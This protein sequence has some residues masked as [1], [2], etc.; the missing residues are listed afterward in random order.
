MAAAGAL[1]KVPEPRGGLISRDDVDTK[2]GIE[3]MVKRTFPMRRRNAARYIAIAGAAFLTLLPLLNIIHIIATTGAN[4]PSS[5]DA[6]FM[7]RFLGRVLD[8]TYDWRFFIR[9]TFFFT[10][11]NLFPA[12]AYIAMARL[13]HFNVYSV[14]Y[15]GILLAAIK[16]A[17]IHNSFT[18]LTGARRGFVSLALWP[19]LSTLVFSVSQISVF[20]HDFQTMCMGFN[21]LGLALGV[22]GLAR[23]PNTLK[24]TLVMAAGGVIA[25]LSFGSGP[26]AWPL[27]LIGL[28]LL[29]CR[30]ILHYAIWLAAAALSTMP[31]IYFLILNQPQGTRS[32]IKSLF[33][34]V[35]VIDTI[36]R[37]FSNNI[38]INHLPLTMATQNGILGLVLLTIGLVLLASRRSLPALRQSVPA[39]SFIASSLLSAWQISIFRDSIAPWYTT[40]SMPFWLGLIG[41]AYVLWTNRAAAPAGASPRSRIIS[42]TPLVWGA[43]T[44]LLIAILFITSNLTFADKTIFLKTRAPASAAS[45]R[46]Y[47]TAP[48]Y[49]ENTL[50]IWPVG[51]PYYMDVMGGLL[52]KHRLSAFSDHQQWTLQGDF[53]LDTVRLKETPGLP[54]VWWSADL[55]A[56]PVPFSDYRHLNLFLHTP[57][58]VSWTVALPANLKQAD[59]HSAI[60]VSEGAPR[61][62]I[63]DGIIFEV[64]IQAGGKSAALAFS[65]YLRAD[66]REWHPFTIP[67]SDYAGQTLTMRLSSSGGGNLADDWAMYRYPYIDLYL[68]GSAPPVN[69]DGQRR[70]SNTDLSPMFIPTTPDDLRLD[71]SDRQLWRAANMVATG[72]ESGAPATWF[73]S[74]QN[75][76]IEYIAPLNVR[77]G[78][79]SHFYIRLSVPPE[80]ER[81]AVKIYYK[82]NEQVGFHEDIAVTI[83]LLGDAGLHAY[84][85]DL[86]LLET[87]Y[88]TRL[89]GI[90]IRPAYGPA[91]TGQN[92]IQI[93]DFRLIKS[94]GSD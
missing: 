90:M 28:V 46:N 36:G 55:S 66:Q 33:N 76:T 29:G 18:H 49:G 42:W 9:D 7:D 10:H 40:I 50:V 27:F 71:V 62:L 52:E 5:D 20:E 61:E 63:A 8:G 23:Y 19:V 92:R 91:A 75:P 84:S 37:P 24:G 56:T 81:R 69:A 86:K 70:P 73:I 25:T 87:S 65:Q 17:L 68:D 21:Q 94:P 83:P 1:G 54:D 4:T 64:Y 47:K 48:T 80:I 60:A 34:Y 58:S 67:L 89:T 45:V 72:K 82:I 35:F 44:L 31:Y 79:Y 41:L 26:I 14:L 39:L 59:F 74:D 38:G 16:L 11:S 6:F 53:L 51:I 2:S 12:L 22:W 30:K 85:Y 57:N 3:P 13:T 78:D 32:T 43:A 88:D 93:T 15:F 77:I